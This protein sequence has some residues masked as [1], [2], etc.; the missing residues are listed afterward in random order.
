M[1]TISDVM[2]ADVFFKNLDVTVK[3]I[4]T[5]HSGG[6]VCSGACSAFDT[7]ALQPGDTR[8]YEVS[9]VA[10]RAAAAD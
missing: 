10:K 6:I 7:D 5:T 4:A 9:W 3:L 8:L 1:K 2:K